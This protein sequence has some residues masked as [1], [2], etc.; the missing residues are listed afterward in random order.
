MPVIGII[1][2]RALCLL[3]ALALLPVPLAAPAAAQ[4]L[5]GERD[6]LQIG[7]KL[8]PPFAMKAPDGAWEGIAIDLLAAVAARL[9]VSYA[10]QET[11]LAGMID[12]VAAGRL[13]ASI[14]AMTVTVAREEVV[15]F[16]HAYYRSGLGVAVADR[17]TAGP[18]ALWEAL[19]SRAFLSVV[20][21]MA[22]LLFAVGTVVWALERR[23]NPAQFE[24]DP[25]RGLFSGFWWAV[26]TMSTT[27][28]GDKA[29]ATVGGR[30]VAILW[31][32]AGL[33]LTAGFTAQLAATLTA[34]AI[35]S[36]V[37]H[38]TDLVRLRVGHVAGAASGETLRGYGVRPR[39][40]DDV[41]AGLAA[42]ARGE[43]DAFVHDEPILA[44]E[45]AAVPGVA[46]APV[47]F[48]PQ[49]YAIVLPQDARLRETVNRALLEVLATDQWAAIQRRYLGDPR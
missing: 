22:G 20:G 36:S 42:V 37:T 32:F 3:V 24:P 38:P 19:T 41:E 12:E 8:A 11:T 6:V 49:D 35:H 2:R 4:D 29:P 18:V 25:R 15:D 27:G 14:A 45:V 7:T 13:D 47:R 28:Y 10:L 39:D 16:S 26:V 5:A 40:Y 46:L 17:R 44:Y 31:I 33:V 1:L 48:A 30:V 23:H 43:I 9:G 34:G 21:V